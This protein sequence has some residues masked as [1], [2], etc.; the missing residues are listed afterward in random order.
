[1]VETK[2]LRDFAIEPSRSERYAAGVR[3]RRGGIG[4]MSI[5]SGPRL[6]EFRCASRKPVEVRASR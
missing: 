5:I 4:R 2:S 1:M 3:G 6:A